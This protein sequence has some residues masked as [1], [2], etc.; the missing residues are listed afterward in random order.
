MIF[1]FLQQFFLL[2]VQFNAGP[3]HLLIRLIMLLRAL[4]ALCLNGCD[5]VV[6]GAMLPDAMK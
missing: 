1:S 3:F 6:C 5:S 4:K 2:I